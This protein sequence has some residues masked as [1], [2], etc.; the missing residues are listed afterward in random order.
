MKKLAGILILT[1]FGFNASAQSDNI[2]TLIKDINNDQLS[3]ICNYGCSL[4]L[5]SAAADSLIKIGKPATEKLINYLDDRERGIIT[6]Y[7]LS[8]IWIKK[9]EL[10]SS[11][12]NYAKD[13][14]IEITF[15]GLYFFEKEGHIYTEQNVL[16]ENKK[17]WI[18]MINKSSR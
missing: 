17:T 16:N 15:C 8:N 14:T 10:S 6:H 3:W 13:K 12:L 7:I 1:I 11:A 9:I 5:N 18:K 4:Y 2:E